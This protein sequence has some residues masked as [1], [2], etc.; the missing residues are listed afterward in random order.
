MRLHL[1]NIRRGVIYSVVVNQI[2]GATTA[3]S[4]TSNGYVVYNEASR[5]A[6]LHLHNIKRRVVFSAI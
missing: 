2:N 1:D 3:N 6:R 5:E 4:D